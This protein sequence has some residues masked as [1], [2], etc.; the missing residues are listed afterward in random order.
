MTKPRSGNL[1]IIPAAAVFDC[2]LSHADVRVLAAL[3]AH[4][5]KNGRCWPATTTLANKTGMSERHARTSLRNLE[6]IGYVVTE[7]R[8]GQSSMYRIPRNQAAGVE[9]NPGTILPEPRNQ[10][11]GDPGT[12]LPP[13]DIKNDTNNDTVA[14]LAAEQFEVFWQTYPSRGRHSNPKKPAR[15]KFDA[16][17]KRGIAAA[18][19]IRGA[20]NYAAYA[21]REI[22]NPKHIAQALTWLNQERWTEHQ[23]AAPARSEA[24]MHL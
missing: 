20:Q 11:A 14:P 7:S 13:N 12:V 6:N 23:E 17:L 15:A 24:G 19:I 3:G 2:R 16:A 1:S 22:S 8:P 21:Q 4:A 9:P 10:A 18:D 5:N